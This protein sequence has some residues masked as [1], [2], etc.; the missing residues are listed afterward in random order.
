MTNQ[1]SQPNRQPFGAD[2]PDWDD[3][4]EV[5]GQYED[6]VRERRTDR[7]YRVGTAAFF[8]L[9]NAGLFLTYALMAVQHTDEN[10]L[11]AKLPYLSFLGVAFS[12]LWWSMVRGSY[13][14][15][16]NNEGPET[17]A[18]RGLQRKAV[19]L[20][21]Y[22]LLNRIPLQDETPPKGVATALPLAFIAIHILLGVILAAI[23]S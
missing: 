10:P 9:L 6:F 3:I 18:R 7:A 19:K 23:A 21:W 15:W 11:P 2:H 5:L 8:L 20:R 4:E 1:Q 14:L 16:K 22:W 13:F 17:R 12:F